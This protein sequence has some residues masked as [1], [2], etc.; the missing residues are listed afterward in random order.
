MEVL[1][2]H[3]NGIAARAYTIVG[4]LR[5]QTRTNLNFRPAMAV[6][7]SLRARPRTPDG[8]KKAPFYFISCSHG[9][10]KLSHMISYTILSTNSTSSIFM[11]SPLLMLPIVE[12]AAQTPVGPA[13]LLHSVGIILSKSSWTPSTIWPHRYQY[14]RRSLA[15]EHRSLKR[16]GPSAGG[17]N[18]EKNENGAS[19]ARAR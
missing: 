1:C 8:D 13:R 18:G 16:L 2:R 14:H 4:F 10:Y 19:D 3:K 12:L 9:A 15:E 7:V 5:W 17:P 6:R 11:W